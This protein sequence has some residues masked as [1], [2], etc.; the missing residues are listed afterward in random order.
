VGRT[1]IH[2]VRLVHEPAKAL[3]V[4][5]A[6]ADP[7]GPRPADYFVYR[8]TRQLLVT[9]ADSFI[10]DRNTNVT[11]HGPTTDRPPSWIN[12]FAPNLTWQRTSTSLKG[13]LDGSPLWFRV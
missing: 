13:E 2:C 3:L 11:S 8:P 7:D 10:N 5:Q 12:S 1:K 9:I 4:R 6:T